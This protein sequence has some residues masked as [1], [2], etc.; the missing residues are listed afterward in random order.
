MRICDVCKDLSKPVLD[1]RLTILKP[2][3]DSTRV[4]PQELRTADI[5]IC[6]DCVAPIW[7]S[8]TASLER[9]RTA[10]PG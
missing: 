7:S 4:K 6:E 5:E 3:P 10:G 2:D 8:V 9:C 1:L